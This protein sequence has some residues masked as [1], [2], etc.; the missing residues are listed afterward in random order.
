[1]IWL[2]IG[3]V[4][5]THLHGDHFRGLPFL[6]LDGRFRRLL[7]FRSRPLG[8][9]SDARAGLLACGPS[10]RVNLDRSEF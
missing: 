5:L 7:E 4:V 6:I 2:N 8:Q 10:R 3:T 1:L 9:R